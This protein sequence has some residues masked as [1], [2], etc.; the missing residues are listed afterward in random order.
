MYYG[1]VKKQD[2]ML[3]IYIGSPVHCGAYEMKGQLP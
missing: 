2:G 1:I 3:L